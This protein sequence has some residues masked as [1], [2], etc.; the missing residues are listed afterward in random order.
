MRIVGNALR[1]KCQWV[2][3]VDNASIEPAEFLRPF[4]ELLWESC[5]LQRWSEASD[6]IR[7]GLS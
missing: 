3:N 6:H 1:D 2:G 7:Q 5:G 4:F